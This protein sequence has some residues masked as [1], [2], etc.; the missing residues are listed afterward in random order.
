MIYLQFTPKL[1]RIELHRNLK[2]KYKLKFDFNNK[3][4]FMYMYLLHATKHIFSKIHFY[5]SNF[6]NI[7]SARTTME[8]RQQIWIRN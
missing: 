1:E 2:L 7:K 6:K 5:K 4:H 3:I 8:P